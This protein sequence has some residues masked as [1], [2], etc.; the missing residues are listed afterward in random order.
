MVILPFDEELVGILLSYIDPV[1]P[2]PKP[3]V[4]RL[5]YSSRTKNLID[6]VG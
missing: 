6:L 2:R 4:N 1:H 5:E 3:E